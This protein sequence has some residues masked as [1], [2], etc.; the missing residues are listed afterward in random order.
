M[1]QWLVSYLVNILWF[2]FFRTIYEEIYKYEDVAPSNKVVDNT[3]EHEDKWTIRGLQ[4][5]TDYLFSIMAL[6]RLGQSK[7]RPDDVK[8]TTS[9]EL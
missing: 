2:Y 1:A 6:N 3:T 4:L 5:A 7:Y 8:A 9:S